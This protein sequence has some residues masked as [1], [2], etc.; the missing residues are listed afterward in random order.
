MPDMNMHYSSYIPE[1]FLVAWIREINEYEQQYKNKLF[2]RNYI[3]NRDVGATVDF[4]SITYYNSP[5]RRAQFIAKGAVPEPFTV[6]TRTKAH[7]MY[8]IA[9]GFMINER[10]L[11]KAEGASMK[12]KEI[13]IAVKNIHKAE[14]YTAMNGDGMDVIGIVG[15]ARANSNGKLTTST[16]MGAWSGSDDTR[17]P[18]EDINLAI[19]YMEDAF[20]P[21]YL[22]GNRADLRYLN[23]KDSERGVFWKQIAELFGK[24]ETDKSWMVENQY[25]PSGYVYIVPYD[26]Q[27]AEFIVSEE[28]DIVD[29]YAK[30]PGGNFWIEIKEWINPIEVHQNEAFVEVAI[31]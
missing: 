5:D 15:A 25:C 12:T 2:A 13:D 6:G 8:Q 31:G 30:Q 29:D 17:D 26:P 20:T 7:P 16:N 4:D 23:T 28:I 1:E 9:E 3:P 24:P 27:A 11:K 21:A 19:T 22:I 18:Y 14:D 10:D